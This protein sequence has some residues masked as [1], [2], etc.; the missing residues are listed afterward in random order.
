MTEHDDYLLD[1][2]TAPDPQVQALE[3]ALAPLRWREVP[4][5]EE[6]P[7]KRRPVQHPRRLWPWLLAAELLGVTLLVVATSGE[8][9]LHRDAAARSFVAKAEP[10]RIPLGELAEITLR[11]GSEVKFV[12][13]RSDQALFQLTRG[14][15]EARV[16]PP[17]AV[18]IGFF[19]VGTPRGLVVDQGCK[20]EL[21]LHDDGHVYVRVTEGAVTF[22]AGER[23]AFVPAGAEVTVSAEGVHTPMFSDVS[24]ELRKSVREYD[25]ARSSGTDYERRAMTIKQVLAAAR[26]PRDTLVVWHLLRDPEPEFRKIAEAHL[27]SLVE[28]PPS[29]KGQQETFDPEEWLPHL[30]LEA[31]QRGQ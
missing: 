10:L 12:H 23:R 16:A 17:P 18:P 21:T 13:W 9:G 28:P 30:R 11:P 31:W 4:L 15:L 22:E 14:G 25:A 5:R 3:R 29:G 24:I 8:R 1:P 7:G 26:S 6:E 27:R 19:C 2:N 20:Y